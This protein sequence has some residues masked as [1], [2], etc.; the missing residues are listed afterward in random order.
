MWLCRNG[1][2]KRN[3]LLR[4]PICGRKFKNSWN[5]L[6]IWCW[7]SHACILI[8][9]VTLAILN[10]LVKEWVQTWWWRSSNESEA[11]AN[12]M[13]SSIGDKQLEQNL[14]QL[15][16]LSSK[17]QVKFCVLNIYWCSRVGCVGEFCTGIVAI[18]K[19]RHIQRLY[20]L[21]ML[22]MVKRSLAQDHWVF[23]NFIITD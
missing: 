8:F 10:L 15:A 18:V 1:S 9:P 16:A 17:W 7:T 11:L 12:W 4:W 14:Q 5:L 23:V 2:K 22:N 13:W 6:S 19:A 20:L 21:E 3:R